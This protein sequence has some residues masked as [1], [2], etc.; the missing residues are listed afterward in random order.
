MR[1]KRLG[2]LWSQLCYCSA[3]IVLYRLYTPALFACMNE[4][5]RKGVVA[6]REQN[7]AEW[8]DRFIGRISFIVAFLWKLQ[9]Q[10]DSEKVKI[11]EQ[12]RLL[13]YESITL[14][15]RELD[16]FLDVRRKKKEVEAEDLGQ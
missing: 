6:I 3:A 9:K 2:M 14:C 12:V 7:S 11:P 4:S 1:T 16:D 8:E 15:E 10:I 5:I 13:I